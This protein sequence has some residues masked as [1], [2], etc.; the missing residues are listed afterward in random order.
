[1]AQQFAA[2]GI[3]NGTCLGANDTNICFIVSEYPLSEIANDA[4]GS[5]PVDQLFILLDPRL[6]L[7]VRR[8]GRRVGSGGWSLW[9]FG[10]Q[11]CGARALRVT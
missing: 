8:V 1:M 11:D 7:R 10:P 9:T 4:F 5:N 2:T 6:A 3:I